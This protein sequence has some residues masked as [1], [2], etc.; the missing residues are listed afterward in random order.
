MRTVLTSTREE[1][2]QS[3]CEPVD[4]KALFTQQE[5]DEEWGRKI[6]SEKFRW[7]NSQWLEMVESRQMDEAEP[8][9]YGDDPDGLEQADLFYSTDGMPHE[10]G[11]SPDPYSQ[12][13]SQNG[14][15]NGCNGSNGR[16][17]TAYGFRPDEHFYHGVS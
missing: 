17:A 11:L 9:L 2:L 14:D 7:H 16:P 8:Y 13:H 3:N 6:Q 1:G 10:A 5:Y 4:C 15:F 12:F